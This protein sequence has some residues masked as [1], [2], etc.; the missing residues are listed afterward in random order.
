MS[1][2]QPHLL[3]LLTAALCAASSYQ[4]QAQTNAV[5]DRQWGTWHIAT[6]VLPGGPKH[7]G[8]YVELQARSNGLFRQYFY[9]EMKAGVS[10]DVA[11]NFTFMVAGG[12]Y[13]TSDYRDLGEG[14]LNIEK[15]LWEQVTFTHYNA[16]LKVEHRYRVEQRWF[17]FPDGVVPAGSTRYRNRIRYRLNGFIPLNHP[18]VTAKTAFL[19]IYDE[20]FFNPK[21]PIFERNRVY[22]GVGY[23]FDPHWTVQAGI[24]RQ[25]N[26]TPAS[27][28][29][30]VFTPQ[31]TASKNNLV[32]SVIYRISRRNTEG[33][34]PEYVPSQPD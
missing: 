20:V 14:P 28:Q 27:Y 33:T 32:L 22:G 19:S 12:R 8:G 4:A 21:G 16:R 10:Y 7:W 31:T 15:R 24:V 3:F 17:S 30:N 25:S 2:P 34:S 23:Q 5:P 9:T 29:Q 13:S 6:A 11:K 18:T 26:F 1:A